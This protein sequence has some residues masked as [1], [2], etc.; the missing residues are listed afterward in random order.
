[1]SWPHCRS[2][3]PAVALRATPGEG[4]VLESCIH[5]QTQ[6]PNARISNLIMFQVSCDDFQ[7]PTSNPGMLPHHRRQSASHL[8]IVLAG[9]PAGISLF[10]HIVSQLAKPRELPASWQ[11]LKRRCVVGAAVVEINIGC[12]GDTCLS[13]TQRCVR[14]KA[15][16]FLILAPVRTS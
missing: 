3:G 6:S 14:R 4:T 9:E 12:I 8:S 7:D 5:I 16:G 1:M 10:E 2:N 11:L 13:A 15:C